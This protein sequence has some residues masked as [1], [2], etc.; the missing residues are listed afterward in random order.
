MARL[1]RG[2][3]FYADLG[4]KNR[5][6]LV[7]QN[8]VGN[9]YSGKVI[10]V[11]LSTQIKRSYPTTCIVSYGKLARSCVHCEE[12]HTIEKPQNVEVFEHLPRR[13]MHRVDKCLAIA[14]GIGGDGT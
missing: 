4:Y 7:V 2:D 13:M 10:V 11:P 3:I 1:R 5:P 8:D 12:I 14:I 6:F 9:R